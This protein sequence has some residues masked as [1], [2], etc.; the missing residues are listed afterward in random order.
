MEVDEGERTIE[1]FKGALDPPGE[2]DASA[3]SLPVVRRRL[4]GH[5]KVYLLS[6]H[7]MAPEVESA[8]TYLLPKHQ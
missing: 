1:L 3:R 8:N 4:G 5:V 2:R 7:R 6:Q